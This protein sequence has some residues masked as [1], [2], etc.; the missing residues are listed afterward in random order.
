MSSGLT[1]INKICSKGFSIEN[2]LGKGVV[3]QLKS[4]IVIRFTEGEYFDSCE[5]DEEKFLPLSYVND[6]ENVTINGNVF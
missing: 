4:D 1:L 2:K 5:N 3:E 6:I